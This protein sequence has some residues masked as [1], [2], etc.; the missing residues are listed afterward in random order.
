[1]QCQENNSVMAFESAGE[2]CKTAAF[3]PV[4]CMLQLLG[5]FIGPLLI[6]LK[7]L[8]GPQLLLTTDLKHTMICCL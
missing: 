5:T 7:D 4:F 8:L 6:A 3:H 1:M 2:C